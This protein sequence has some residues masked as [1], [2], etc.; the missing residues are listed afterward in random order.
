MQRALLER[1]IRDVHA[2]LVR[3]REELAVLDEQLEV[4]LESADEARVRSLV[5]ETPLAA[6]E[7]SEAKRH[8]DAMVRARAAQASA[9]MDLERRQDELLASVS[10]GRS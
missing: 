3:A 9:V 6:H 10:T 5:S 1:R 2:R 4:V 7:H 8:A